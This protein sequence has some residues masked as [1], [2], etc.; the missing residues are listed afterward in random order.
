MEGY[1][2]QKIIES[3]GNCAKMEK[4]TLRKWV[5]PGIEQSRRVGTPKR[6]TQCG[7]LFH[8]DTPQGCSV[9]EEKLARS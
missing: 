2:V 4:D 8:I 9:L 5:Q 7:T 6:R 1:G 3:S